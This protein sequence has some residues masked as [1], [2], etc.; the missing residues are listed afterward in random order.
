MKRFKVKGKILK[1]GVIHLKDS[2]ISLNE[3]HAQSFADLI[4]ALADEAI[5]IDDP[6]LIQELDKNPEEDKPETPSKPVGRPR[7]K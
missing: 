1:D 3:K 2:V 4:E 6:I 7:K 5:I